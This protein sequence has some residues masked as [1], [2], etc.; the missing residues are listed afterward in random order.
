MSMKPGATTRPETSSTRSAAPVRCGATATMR[1]PST[2][3]SAA[4]PGAP[5]PSTTVPPR[6]RSDQ[7]TAIPR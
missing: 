3:T 7:A 6:K 5:V 1:S 2:A 4:R